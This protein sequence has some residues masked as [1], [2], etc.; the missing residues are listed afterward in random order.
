[1]PPFGLQGTINSPLNLINVFQ[2]LKDIR[3]ESAEVIAE[4]LEQNVEQLFFT[5]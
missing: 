4:Q 5:L 3:A 1:M 2:A